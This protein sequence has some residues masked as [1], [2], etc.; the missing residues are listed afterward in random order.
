MMTIQFYTTENMGLFWDYVK[1]LLT[2]I[3][4][5]I[6]LAFAVVCVGLLLGIIIKAW[7]QSAKEAEEEDEIEFRNY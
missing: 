6:M 5:G 7:K 2:G 4:P 1:M 3:A